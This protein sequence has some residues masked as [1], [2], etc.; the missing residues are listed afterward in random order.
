MATKRLFIGLTLDEEATRGL[1]KV[2]KVL[3][4]KHWP[5]RFEAQE[6]WHVTLQFLGSVEAERIATLAALVEV[7][8]VNQE[9]FTLG[10]K[11]LGSFPS[12]LLPR[13][14]FVSVNGDLHALHRLR[15]RIVA[16]LQPHGFIDEVSAFHPHVT[17]GRV[18][19]Y[20]KR[21]P[22]LE[23]GKEI[24]KQIQMDIPQQWYVRSVSIVESTL[25]KT[26]SVYTPIYTFSFQQQPKGL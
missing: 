26:G 22:R 25:T 17:L 9:P 14:L 18:Q 4:K 5:I 19:R 1:T 7:A 10:F 2:I 21:K 20:T 11:G 23:L 13:T 6:K 15:K 3:Q 12:L 24:K 16:G 8:A